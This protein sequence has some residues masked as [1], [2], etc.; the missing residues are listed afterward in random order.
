MNFQT[1]K[2]TLRIYPHDDAFERFG[3]LFQ[4][5]L[6]PNGLQ[7]TSQ[8]SQMSSTP[9][10]GYHTPQL[11]PQQ[12]SPQPVTP[13]QHTP[14]AAVARRPGWMGEKCAKELSDISHQMPSAIHLI[15]FVGSTHKLRIGN[16]GDTCV[17][18][19]QHSNY[20]H[21]RGFRDAKEPHL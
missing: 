19:A 16:R 14:E 20:R 10:P 7:E 18:L 17:F 9:T 5:L 13:Q 12:L 15:V 1:T 11:T 2:P 4:P 21:S 3:H 6:P 8:T